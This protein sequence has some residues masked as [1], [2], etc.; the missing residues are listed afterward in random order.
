MR[1]LTAAALAALQAAQ[2]GPA[3][4]EPWTDPALPVKP[5]LALWFDATRR[6]ETPVRLWPD[7]SGHRR[8]LTQESEAC[9]PALRVDGASAAVRFDGKD[10]R[11][12]GRGPGLV[13]SLTLVAVFAPHQNAGG[14]RAVLSGNAPGK[15][16]YLTGLNLDLGGAGREIL[17]ALNVE[18]AGFP[19]EKNLLGAGAL[20]GTFHVVSLTV[21]AGGGPGRIRLHVDGELRGHTGREEAEIDLSEFR[22]G[23]R[24]YSNTAAPAFESGYFHGDVAEVLL[25]DRVL[26]EKELRSVEEYLK[27]KYPALLK[28]EALAYAPPPAVQMIV[29]GFTVRKLPVALTNINNLEYAPDGRLFALGYDGRIHV[30]TDSDGD[31]LEDAAR[32]W[33]V[34]QE[35][36]LRGPIGMVLAPEGLYV[37]S[38]G[39]VSLVRDT[40]GDG[41]ADASEVVTTG[42]KEITQ[43]VDA[44]GLAKD[45]EGNLYFGLGC[46]NFANA[47]LLDKD[48]KAHYDIKSERGTLLKL[49]PDRTKREVV[50]TGV[51]FTIGIAFNRHGDLFC[52]DQEGETWLP[53]GNPLDE[54]LHIRPGKH[55]GFPPRHPKH[56]PDVVD[57]PAVAT[58]GPQHQ[59]TCGLK[60]NE[61][62]EGWKPFGPAAWEGDALVIGESRGK[63]WRVPLV[64]TAAGYV[65]KPILIGSQTMLTI[66]GA[67]SK[68][69]DLVICCHSGLPDW[70]TGPKG[71]G[72]LFKISYSDR[73]AP[74]PVVAWASG[75]VEVKVAFDRPVDPAELKEASIVFGEFVSAADRLEAL[76]PPYKVV[77]EQKRCPRPALRVAGMKLSDD[78]RTLTLSTASHPWEATYAL[79][80]SRVGGATVDLAYDLSGLEATWTAEGKSSPEWSGWVPH[81]DPQV[82]RR[83]TAGSAEHER[84]FALLER[85]GTLRYRGVISIPGKEGT[86]FLSSKADQGPSHQIRWSG[87]PVEARGMADTGK[88]LE[89]R[90]SYRSE[91]HPDGQ[92]LRLEH[93]RLPWAPAHKPPRP[94]EE[95]GASPLGAG[96]DWTR[97]KALFFGEAKCGTC[98]T[99]RGEGGKVAPEL[100]NLVHWA[101]ARILREIVEPSAT[102]N[103]DYVNHLVELKDGRRLA[104]VVLTEGAD[105][106]RIVDTDAKEVI[107]SRG[108]I[109]QMKPSTVSIMPEGFKAL[110]EEKLRD[111][112]K[113]LT[114]E[115][116]PKEQGQAPPPRS[117]AEVEAVLKEATE[118]G[119]AHPREISVVLVTGP[120]D[121]GPG[122]HD[123]PAWT[124]KWKELLARQPGVR[125]TTAFKAPEPAHWEKADLMVLYFMD[126][127]FWNDERYGAVDAYL[128]RG[129]GLFLMH[130]AVIPEKEPEKLA[131]RIGLAWEPRKTKYR[132]GPLDLEFAGHALTR[133]LKKISLVDESYWPL[134]GDLAKVEVLA[135]TIEDGKPQPMIWSPRREKGRVV[136]SILG[137]Y[138]WTFEDPLARLLMLRAMAWAAGEPL[139][140]FKPLVTEGAI[141]RD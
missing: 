62:R 124:A 48:G 135:T 21:A 47:Y 67:V 82:I 29:P 23:A 38:K 50:C 8:D 104:G 17:G 7:G 128:A 39:K 46:A 53:G 110:G 28:G 52:T 33:W 97:G 122:E 94:V 101:P 102:L 100:T 114:A 77:D 88:N 95:A 96:G 2:A 12:S 126:G 141:L 90:A 13:K 32:P 84:L 106:L 136:C 119:P 139:D 64:K 107:V 125:L 103:P 61:A 36:D 134:A 35:G 19:G 109:A 93:V 72:A 130:S 3:P 6:L 51:R 85:P 1:I 20:L 45:K 59:S 118:T 131:A 41:A 66:D 138:A 63:I 27:K 123:Y 58:F 5:G 43:A 34:K 115:A 40:D 65:G 55:Y 60:F 137:H 108:E 30:L 15:N 11:L 99:I 22:L 105:R 54:L 76:H 74:Q 111:L 92:P 98:H 56:L 37:A 120:K 133:G 68:A 14:Y 112:L 113:F 83:L 116:A 26:P 87:R 71:E 70:G 18:G 10:D 44:V 117:R 42:W 127:K 57:E 91:L 9:R 16:D 86:I 31:G 81:P 73:K 132:H 75:P 4:A 129:G 140:R 89:V 25:Y 69:G 49:S 79:T 78:R 24:K 121:H 80:I